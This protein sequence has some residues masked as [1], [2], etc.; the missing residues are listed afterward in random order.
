MG[1]VT[2]GSG[3]GSVLK[4]PDLKAI[5][6]V[7]ITGHNSGAAIPSV[8]SRDIAQE[9]AMS[10]ERYVNR[11][12]LALLKS[13]YAINGLQGSM[14]TIRPQTGRMNGAPVAVA[15]VHSLSYPT[16]EKKYS[17]CPPLD[18]GSKSSELLLLNDAT[19]AAAALGT[20]DLKTSIPN[21]ALSASAEADRK[22]VKMVE[23]AKKVAALKARQQK[24]SSS[25]L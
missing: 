20:F 22:L 8:H 12:C 18:R 6:D 23:M 16:F 4:L 9:I 19:A 15:S 11:H 7:F 14:L 21:T 24:G 13:S 10:L 5:D 25:S 3:I 2:S 1:T 17:P